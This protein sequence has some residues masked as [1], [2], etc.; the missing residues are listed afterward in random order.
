MRENF[1]HIDQQRG[2]ALHTAI[3]TYQQQ[4]LFIGIYSELKPELCRFADADR[5]VTD[6]TPAIQEQLDNQ[7]VTVDDVLEPTFEV[8]TC[9]RNCRDREIRR[10]QKQQSVVPLIIVKIDRNNTHRQTQQQQ[11]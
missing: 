6:K 1:L 4:Q 3:L 11:A 5:P 7:Q 8:S 9:L 10:N 2:A